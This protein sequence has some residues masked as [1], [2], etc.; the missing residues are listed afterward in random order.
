VGDVAEN[1]DSDRVE[2]AFGVA[3]SMA[4]RQS[5]SQK[6][7]KAKEGGLPL[8]GTRCGDAFRPASERRFITLMIPFRAFN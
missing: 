8:S 3:I 7:P 5:L 4:M 2:V 1:F 6:A